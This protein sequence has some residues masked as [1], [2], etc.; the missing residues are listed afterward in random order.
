MD[1]QPDV[2]HPH[3][4]VPAAGSREV[5]NQ[6][7]SN[8]QIGSGDVNVVGRDLVQ[9]HNHHV[10]HHHYA[11]ESPAIPPILDK[12]PNLRDI[13]IETLGK[14]TE[15]TGDWIYVWNE[16]TIWLASDG[17]IRILWGSGMPGAGKSVFASLAINAV[18]AHA[19]A[20]TTPICIG[21]LYIRYSAN[22]KFSVRDLLEILVKQ[23][24]ERHP[25]A[26]PLCQEVYD[27]HI[28]EKTDP[29][30]KELVWLLKRFTS[31]LMTNTFYFLDALDEAPANVRLDLLE[32]LTP[33]NV[34]LFIT[35]RPLNGLEARFPNTHRF[36]IC[37]QDRDLNVHIN[38]EISRSLELQ[39]ILAASSPGL[40]GRIT[41]AIKRK[42]SGM[43]LHASLHLQA[44]QECTSRQELDRTLE[45]FPAKIADVYAR[46]WNRILNQ[47]LG[48]ALLAMNVLRWVVFATRSLAI[49]ELRHAIASCPDTHNYEPSRLVAP[50]TLVGVCCGLILIE[51]ETRQVRLIIPPRPFFKPS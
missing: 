2:E 49:E 51:K 3:A 20:A 30:T 15:G 33:L 35:S 7:L 39:A 13:H 8:V 17:Y 36:P 24:I 23:T 47:G 4:L 45:E 31:E 19:K 26:L 16:F 9:I 10:H 46:T 25:A 14:A 37:A 41:L 32:A 21:Y 12:V 5:A 43:F 42:C 27:R 22:T 11:V 1:D 18:E 29:S 50:Q 40:D 44:L 28:R 48:K 38:R 34:K 6:V